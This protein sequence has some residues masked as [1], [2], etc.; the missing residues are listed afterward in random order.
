[1][2]TV[3][4]TPVGAPTWI[5]L[6]SSDTPRAVEFYGQLFGWTA[7]HGGEEY[8]GYINFLKDGVPV[9]GCM[10][11]DGST[12]MPDVWSVYLASDDA[13]ATVEAAAAQ[14][15]QV[16]LPAM[17]VM[18]L[19]RMALV[20]DPGQAAVGIWQPGLHQG[21]GVV[22]EPGTPGWFELHTRDYDAAVTFYRDVF[23]WDA[24]TAADEP[25]FRY[26]TFG[27]GES[28]RAGI[29]DAGFLLPEGVPNHWSIYF[30]VADTDA[31]LARVVE[32]GGAVVRPGED[33]PFGRLAAATDPAGTQFKLVG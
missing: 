30:Q 31:A 2:P 15:G 24:H 4:T 3:T 10:G 8:G 27:E 32:L 33:T 22:A 9:A 25:G 28:A 12:G 1:M 13:A 7:E 26:T 21:F 23:Q 19:G 16:H 5:D 17:D 18:E 20:A 29:M 6:F 11:H 14:G